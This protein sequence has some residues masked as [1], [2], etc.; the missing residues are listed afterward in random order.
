VAGQAL[1]VVWT[2]ANLGSATAQPTWYDAVY[3][4]TNVVLDGQDTQLRSQSLSF[5]VANGDTL[6]YIPCYGGC[7]NPCVGHKSNADCYVAERFPDARIIF[8]SHAAG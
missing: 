3:F 1:T 6:R 8:T 4:S 7:G 2:V 5:A